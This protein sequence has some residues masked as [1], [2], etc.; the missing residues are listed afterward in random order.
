MDIET[1]NTSLKN[2]MAE[3]ESI[4]HNIWEAEIYANIPLYDEMI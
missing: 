1:E 4:Q 2:A 3:I